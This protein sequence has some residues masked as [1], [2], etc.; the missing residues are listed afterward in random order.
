[1]VRQG[2]AL[3]SH[4]QQ[5]ERCGYRYM[6]CRQGPKLEALCMDAAPSTRGAPT[7]SGAV[8]CTCFVL[9]HPGFYKDEVNLL[10]GPGKATVGHVCLTTMQYHQ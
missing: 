6:R 3:E 8:P 2:M 10:H 5:S 9:K 7:R 4:T 1:M